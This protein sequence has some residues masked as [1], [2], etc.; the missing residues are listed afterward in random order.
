MRC[1]W[2]KS[3]KNRR[4]VTRWIPAAGDPPQTPSF[5]ILYCY[6]V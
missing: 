3:C 5:L 1:F 2:K 4:S 6:N